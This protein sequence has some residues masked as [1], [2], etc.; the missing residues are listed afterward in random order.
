MTSETSKPR[1]PPF[2]VEAQLN[3]ESLDGGLLPGE[4]IPLATCQPFLHDGLTQSRA[5]IIFPH[6][7]FAGAPGNF[8]P[9]H[10]HL[11]FRREIIVCE[12]PGLH[13]IWFED[14]VFIKPLPQFLTNHEFWMKYVVV[15]DETYKLACGFLYSYSQFIRYESDFRL[16]AEKGLIRDKE[17]TWEKWQ[18]FRLCLLDVFDRNPDIMDKRYL[19]GELRLS[20]LNL[21]YFIKF[22]RCNLYYGYWNRHTHYGPIFSGYFATAVVIFAFASI[23]LNA[24]QVAT[25]QTATNVSPILLTTSYRFSVAILI[26]IVAI[27]VVIMIVFIPVIARDLRTGMIAN[28]KMAMELR[29]QSSV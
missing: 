15:N 7:W 22:R 10:Q 21:I 13:L 14:R 27:M 12:D 18:R 8:R 5:N 3:S 17:L 29:R 25:S 24:M 4:Y 28:K 6:L 2:P 16:A 26:A 20:R 23:T 9:L 19:Y 1:P 11:V